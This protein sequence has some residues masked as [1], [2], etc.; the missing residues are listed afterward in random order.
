MN[1]FVAGTDTIKF[2]NT[3]FGAATGATGF[4]TASV[5]ENKA[6]AVGHGSIVELTGVNLTDLTVD[7]DGGAI[8]NAIITAIDTI[9]SGVYLIAIND[10]TGNIGLYDLAT[11]ANGGAAT[12]G[13]IAIE[14]IGILNLVTDGAL[15]AGNFV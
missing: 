14:L 4:T 5:N 11:T 8:E 7:A 15:A 1:G 3:A 13:N 12:T 6:I 10:N 9:A 2:I